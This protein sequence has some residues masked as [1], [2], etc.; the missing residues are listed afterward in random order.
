MFKYPF[1]VLPVQVSK[2]RIDGSVFSTTDFSTAYQQVTL[3]PETQ[4]LVH[5]VVGNAEYKNK[6]GIS[7]L[8]VLLGSFT[9]LLT[10]PW[11]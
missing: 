8:K 1:P 10:R 2:P 7:G 6:R 9:R 5:F 11:F 4:K 3:T